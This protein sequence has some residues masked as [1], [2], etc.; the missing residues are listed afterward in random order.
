[1]VCGWL[2]QQIWRNQGYG[3]A[4]VS[5]KQINPHVVQE[6]TVLAKEKHSLRRKMTSDHSLPLSG[7]SLCGNDG[8]WTTDILQCPFLHWCVRIL[9]LFEK[10]VVL[11][12]SVATC[13][14]SM[15]TQ[16]AGWSSVDTL[17][18]RILEGLRWRGW[19][20]VYSPCLVTWTL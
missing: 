5:Y 19:G 10:E 6:S 18:K 2:N 16:Y 14:G 3:E 20:R 11:R 1:M 4:T 12:S 7:P 13:S 17:K 15:V 9:W 8:R